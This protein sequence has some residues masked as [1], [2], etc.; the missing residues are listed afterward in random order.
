MD[1]TVELQSE[2]IVRL[3]LHR[4]SHFHWSPG[5]LV[6]LTMPSV[7]RIPFEAHP[8]TIS[9]IDSPLFRASSVG[10]KITSQPTKKDPATVS[11]HMANSSASGNE[12]VFFINVRR[13]FTARLRK[14]ATEGRPVKAFVDGPYGVPPDL[15]SYDVSLLVAGM[16]IL[17]WERT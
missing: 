4:S 11:V 17:H 12:L 13:G 10:E 15:R 8:F 16:Y 7:S 5:Q 6:Y 9:S 14:A 2:D 3:R 1:A